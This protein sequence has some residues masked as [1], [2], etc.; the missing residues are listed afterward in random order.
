M[1]NWLLNDF[2][3]KALSLLIAICLWFYLVVI[4]DPETQITV[5]CPVTYT[6]K[7]EV[8]ANGLVI[9]SNTGENYHKADIVVKGS[10]KRISQA[11]SDDIRATIDLSR[12][13][14]PGRYDIAI[15]A[16]VRATAAG[17]LSI[18]SI[19]PDKVTIEVDKESTKTLPIT[20]SLKGEL[21]TDYLFGKTSMSEDNVTI[22]G[23][24][25]EVNDIESAVVELNVENQKDDIKEKV[26]VSL[27]N[28]G[29][30]VN[31]GGLITSDVESVEVYYEVLK[32]K[33]VP[34]EPT[35]TITEHQE[36]IPVEVPPAPVNDTTETEG[37]AEDFVEE[38]PAPE[39]ELR[40]VVFEPIIIGSKDVVIIGSEQLVDS[41]DVI[42]T[43][44]IN[45]LTYKQAT[46]NNEY[47][48]IPENI[49]TERDERAVTIKINR[50]VVD[51]K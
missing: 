29:G 24:Q 45:P 26:H 46:V 1:K 50:K 16:T 49:T 33:R 37:E 36:L 27:I 34:I 10:R 8:T 15:D 4:L 42:Y 17:D 20:V 47:L 35:L 41:I 28:S 2:L 51:N 11:G 44:P 6:Q 14:S 12:C 9:V 43:R 18:V 48:M 19:N 30:S 32:R 23:P 13:N 3:T 25:T 40:T 38:V 39:T 5:T 7:T 21:E 22:K 31:S